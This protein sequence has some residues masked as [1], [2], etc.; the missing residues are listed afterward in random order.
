MAYSTIQHNIT[1]RFFKERSGTESKSRIDDNDNHGWRT[2]WFKTRD[3][4]Q[5]SGVAQHQNQRDNKSG[6]M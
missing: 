2:Q 1:L 3:S 4:K 6:K 5:S